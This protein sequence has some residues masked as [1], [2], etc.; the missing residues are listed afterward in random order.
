MRLEWIEDILA[1]LKT[2][3]LAQ[4]AE[5]RL[6]TQSAFSRRI[7]ALEN[8]LGAPLFDRTA[9]PLRPLPAV[10]A[11]ESTLRELAS[12]LRAV[13]QA[14]GPKAA[15]Q[16]PRVTIAGSHSLATTQAPLLVRGIHAKFGLGVTVQSADRDQAILSL[17]SGEADFALFF[18][19]AE[20]NE[21][22]SRLDVDVASIGEDMLLPVATRDLF[23]QVMTLPDAPDEPDA[24]AQP[25]HPSVTCPVITYPDEV[26][27][28][29]LINQRLLPQL[30]KERTLDLV[31]TTPLSHA[32]L[33]LVLQ[34]SGVGWLPSSL[35]D[36]HLAEGTLRQLTAPFP[37]APLQLVL[38]RMAQAQSSEIAE[39][40]DFLRS[41]FSKE[42]R[43]KTGAL[44]ESSAPF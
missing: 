25:S 29:R 27:F 21:V 41:T 43:K 6:R 4:A 37:T 2:G 42:V 33:Q 32:V 28:G 38:V 12:Q 26:F 24:P 35:V 39:I 16:R 20:G 18:Q 31:A 13:E 8:H 19:S 14:L 11:Q 36:Q 34:G 30:A 5:E 9:K 10:L 1:V 22:L 40:W 23:E 15:A 44:P 3:S 17:L 7:A